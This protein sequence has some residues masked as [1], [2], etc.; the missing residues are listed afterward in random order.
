[1]VTGS[2]DGSAKLWLA[3][4]GEEVRTL[5]GQRGVRRRGVLS[6]A[7]SPGG[8]LV[9]TGNDNG[10]VKLWS[11][12]DG[13]EVRTLRVYKTRTNVASLAFS[14]DRDLIVTGGSDLVVK[15]WDIPQ[16]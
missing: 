3:Q 7:F 10:E 11:V 6:V 8:G 5:R 2:W 4:T 16:D 15:M 13:E 14:P 12:S 1:M 9:A